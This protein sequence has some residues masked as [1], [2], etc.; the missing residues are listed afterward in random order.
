MQERYGWF[1]TSPPRIWYLNCLRDLSIEGTQL[2]IPFKKKAT[3]IRDYEYMKQLAKLDEDER[4]ERLRD[5]NDYF[6]PVTDPYNSGVYLRL[7]DKEGSDDEL[8]RW[9]KNTLPRKLT[10]SKEE[11]MNRKL[12]FARHEPPLRISGFVDRLAQF[13]LA[14]IGGASLIVPM[15]IMSFHASKTK[16]LVTVSFAVLLFSF[17]LSM[18]LKLQNDDVL[19]ATAA[20]AAVLVVF[21]GTST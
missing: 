3:A 18:A 17:V 16:S 8:R 13:I 5:L 10:Y 20:Y 11:R 12:E 4:T 2:T 9:L 7:E 19:A 6:K 15:L 14:F 21:V 1:E